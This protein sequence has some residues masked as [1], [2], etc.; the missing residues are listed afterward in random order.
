M[1]V[2]PLTPP[3]GDTIETFEYKGWT[4]NLR[5]NTR[6]NIAYEADRCVDRD[7]ILATHFEFNRAAQA[8]LAAR[9]HIDAL[10]L[11]RT[12]QILADELQCQ[13]KGEHTD[14]E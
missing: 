11:E 10:E 4:V 14:V 2:T 12:K 9:Q 3:P 7:E 8:K 13:L 1:V 5:Q 6:G